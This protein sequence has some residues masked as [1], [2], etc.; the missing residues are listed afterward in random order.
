LRIGIFFNKLEG[1]KPASRTMTN[2]KKTILGILAVGIGYVVLQGFR[3]VKNIQ[4]QVSNIK[5]GGSFSNPEIYCNFTVINPTNLS[6]T[7]DAIKGD[8]LYHNEKVAQAWVMDPFTI[9]GNDQ[10]NFSVRLIPEFSSAINLIGQLI[11]GSLDKEFY[12]VG[13][14]WAGTIPFDVNQKIIQ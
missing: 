13:R 5:I 12:F 7:I 9:K 1:V 14:I 3:F 11:S 10:I 4:I 6:V 2:T 8:I